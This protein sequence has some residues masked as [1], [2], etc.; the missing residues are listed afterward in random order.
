ML[1][2]ERRMWFGYNKSR[3]HY[4]IYPYWKFKDF[5]FLLYAVPPIPCPLLPP[6][7][8]FSLCSS[9]GLCA[10]LVR[11]SRRQNFKLCAQQP[12]HITGTEKK[13]TIVV[14]LILIL[15][16]TLCPGHSL[17]ACMVCWCN[18]Q[19]FNS[20][21]NSTRIVYNIA[22]P[23]CPRLFS[24]YCKAVVV[25]NHFNLVILKLFHIFLTM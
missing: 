18:N 10:V 17:L 23:F 25:S 8:Y 6:L 5:L 2:Y 1:L 13:I 24:F 19:G 20:N 11:L 14:M 9:H 15:F 22:V 7:L 12:A 16:T 4:F 3:T 21:F